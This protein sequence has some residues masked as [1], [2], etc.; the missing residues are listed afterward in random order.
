MKT[1]EKFK[2]E[3]QG[4]GALPIV[5]S[6]L[7]RIKLHSRLSDA[8]RGPR[9]ADSILLLLKN[10]L[11]ERNAIYAI[12]EWA[13]QFDHALVHGGLIGDDAIA[14]AL[15]EVFELDRASFLSQFIVDVVK[16][17]KIDVS[18]LHQDTT[19]ITVSGAYAKQRARGVQLKN[20][21]SKDH[22]PD[23]K[24]LIYELSVTRDGAIPVLFKAHDGNQTDDTLHWDNWQS[25]RG[26]VGRAD[27]LYVADSKLCVKKTLMKIDQAKGRFVTIVPRTREETREF[28][29]QAASGRVRWEHVYTKRSTRKARRM[30]IFDVAL[31][32]YQLRE[33]FRV[34]WFRS[35]EKQYRDEQNREERIELA[36]VHLKSL[37][38]PGR[39]K[40]RTEAA[41]QRRADK[42]LTRFK[43]SDWI[44]IEISLERVEEFKQKTRGPATEETDYRKLIKWVPR[45]SAKR[46][47]ERIAKSAA[48]DGIFPL[49][50]NTDLKP[51][52]V[53]N[54]YKYQPYIEKRHA[55][56]KS[57]LHVAPV[58]LKKNH[59]IEA[60]MFVYYSG[61]RKLDRLLSYK[62][63][64]LVARPRR[65]KRCGND[66]Q[67]TWCE[68][69]VRRCA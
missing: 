5:E 27:F 69:E 20:G 56:L 21:H 23:L 30:D 8:L 45:L 15:D 9:H 38:E 1:Q 11:I 47:L 37:N 28:A 26:I 25:L 46:D 14:R 63:H 53:L 52:E 51:A 41:F 58:F 33:G 50:T 19:S 68:A 64:G 10:V 16:E 60:L 34:H 36:F 65:G 29:E 7:T 3:R 54:A 66:P 61:P 32:P 13:Q 49:A 40:P 39:K 44:R 59:R 35:S 17:F 55:L 48:M 42:I 2:L 67:K 62:I 31:G 24:Q 57:G 6:L 4:L 22:R 18:E 43:V 12:R